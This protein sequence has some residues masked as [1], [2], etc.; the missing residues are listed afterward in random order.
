MRCTE[1]DIGQALLVADHAIN[2]D[3]FNYST[4]ARLA[5]T[6]I[7][8]ISDDVK[9]GVYI[10]CGFITSKGLQLSISRGDAQHLMASGYS[11]FLDDTGTVIFQDHVSI[12]QNTSE[13][14]IE[15]AQ[16]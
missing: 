5:V 10:E 13:T 9:A 6:G 14:N 7:R 15:G 11:W 4:I 1:S 12:E 16:E 3:V 2:T 8:K